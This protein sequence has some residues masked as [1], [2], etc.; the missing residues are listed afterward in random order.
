VRRK[1][2]N[3]LAVLSLLLC[4]AFLSMWIRASFRRDVCWLARDNWI[5][6]A[7]IAKNAAFVGWSRTSDS[8][9]GAPWRPI[10]EFHHGV[11]RPE[12]G[13]NV[14]NVEEGGAADYVHGEGA[15]FAFSIQDSSFSKGFDLMIPLWF[16][17]AVTAMLPAARYWLWRSAR[18][19]A[20]S[21]A[22]CGYDLRATPN[23]C[24]ECGTVPS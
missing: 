19:R 7:D 11:L 2:L 16:C 22:K 18:N 20:G 24:P 21:C 9:L 12:T 13:V 17:V 15:G 10:L 1:V 6:M 14:W 3:S 23:R 5:V 4:A 8:D